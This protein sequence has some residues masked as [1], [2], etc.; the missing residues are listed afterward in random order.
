MSV[1]QKEVQSIKPQLFYYFYNYATFSYDKKWLH[2]NEEYAVNSN[3]TPHTDGNTII[4]N[5][6]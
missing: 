3:C 6:S 5:A 2:S 4:N 1:A